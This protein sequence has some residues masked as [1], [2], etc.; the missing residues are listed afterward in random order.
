VVHDVPKIRVDAQPFVFD[1]SGYMRAHLPS[2]VLG[3]LT[4]LC[5]SSALCG[6]NRPYILIR[7]TAAKAIEATAE[8]Q[9]KTK[10]YF[11]INQ[12]AAPFPGVC[13]NFA[14]ARDKIFMFNGYRE[15]GE[16]KFHKLGSQ[17]PPYRWPASAGSLDLSRDSFGKLLTDEIEPCASRQPNGD[18]GAYELK[19][20][21]PVVEV[22]GI[23][24]DGNRAHVDFTWHFESLNEV[25]RI[26]LQGTKGSRSYFWNGAAELVEYDDGWRVVAIDLTGI[27]HF[28]WRYGTEEWPDPNFNWGT[29]DEDENHW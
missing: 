7:P 1:H 10:L 28:K 13:H 17:S 26:L 3:V 14:F 20:G 2:R 23:R 19:L 9:H 12:A 29:F 21:D 15:K 11:E 24:K 16:L 22:N 6:C 27:G 25:G 4:A 5:L 8:F 18:T